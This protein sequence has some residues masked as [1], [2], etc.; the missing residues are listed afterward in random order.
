MQ[1]SNFTR[2]TGQLHHPPFQH[3]GRWGPT[4]SGLAVTNCILLKH[5]RRFF[6]FF[7]LQ[8]KY[9]TDFYEKMSSAKK[10]S[11]TICEKYIFF[12]S[13]IFMQ[14]ASRVLG[15]QR[16]TPAGVRIKQQKYASKIISLP[17]HLQAIHIQPQCQG[18]KGG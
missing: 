9:R 17:V 2:L 14:Q 16:P 1:A 6:H 12:S 8:N 10:S 4:A 7:K 18:G 11:K 13:N 3:V 5:F 15:S